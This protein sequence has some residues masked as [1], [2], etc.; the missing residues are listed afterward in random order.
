MSSP[1]SYSYDV[2]SEVS[3]ENDVEQGVDSPMSPADAP[4]L[5]LPDGRPNRGSVLTRVAMFQ[6]GAN[7][8][9]KTQNVAVN[10]DNFRC[11]H[12]TAIQRPSHRMSVGS[13]SENTEKRFDVDGQAYTKSH[14][15]Q[16][17]G[18]DAGLYQW[19]RAAQEDLSAFQKLPT[20]APQDAAYGRFATPA[21]N[22]TARRSYTMD[23]KSSSSNRMFG[24]SPR[25]QSLLTGAIDPSRASFKLVNNN[26]VLQL[27]MEHIPE[28]QMQ[29]FK[30]TKA[31]A[32]AAELP[33][34]EPIEKF[35]PSS[36]DYACW[37][38]QN[39]RVTLGHPMET[40]KP[41]TTM[42]W[43]LMFF[44]AILAIM[45]FEFNLPEKD[46]N[47]E[48]E[49]KYT[50]KMQEEKQWYFKF[51]DITVLNMVLCLVY[52]LCMVLYTW[53]PN[54]NMLRGIARFIQ[55]TMTAWTFVGLVMYP[56]IVY[57]DLDE[58][59]YEEIAVAMLK[60]VGV[61]AIVFTE[62]TFSRV[63]FRGLYTFLTIVL[64]LV[65]LALLAF[66]MVEK[67]HQVYP[68]IDVDETYTLAVGTLMFCVGVGG[69][70]WFHATIKHNQF[71]CSN[72]T[73]ACDVQIKST[74]SCIE[75][76]DSDSD[77]D[78][79]EF[80]CWDNKSDAEFSSPISAV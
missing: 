32:E 74:G 50:I 68:N 69:F 54:F 2:E 26:G 23:L 14:F 57:W 58:Q 17:Y 62:F 53:M 3:V 66:V 9:E 42:L 73:I 8:N 38:V 16:Y 80:N 75:A 76:E 52:F 10:Q 22:S 29:A 1:Y 77:C 49:T 79:E 43:R 7:E 5:M 78:S 20:A 41:L 37:R 13:N 4:P 11:E 47:D 35:Q 21:R 24:D 28:A 61:A 67:E 6:S 18:E 33:D 56:I 59:A 31:K 72:P 19:N 45:L 36:I 51:A 44:V 63:P 48:Q 46:A 64:S 25:R 27:V 55:P 12:A 34:Y 15:I 39:W 71:F 70:A 65:Y 30:A 40:I 60:T